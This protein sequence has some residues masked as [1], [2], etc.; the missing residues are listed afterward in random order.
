[1]R[2][3]IKNTKIKDIRPKPK[4]IQSPT[5]LPKARDYLQ[6]SK[7]LASRLQRLMQAIVVAPDTRKRPGLTH[8]EC[9]V[10][11]E[12]YVDSKQR[13]DNAHRLYPDVFKHLKTCAP[14]RMSYELLT[15]EQAQ[16]ENYDLT[17]SPEQKIE[18]PFLVPATPNAAWSKQVHSCIGGGSLGFGFT[19]SPSHLARIMA[20]PAQIAVRGPIA[21]ARSLLL[22]DSIALGSRSVQVELWL[23]RSENPDYTRL[24]V[25]VVSSSPLPEPLRVKLSWNDHQYSSAIEQGQGWIDQI[26]VSDLENANISVEFEAGQLSTSTEG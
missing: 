18:L 6:N 24:E 20:Q 7:S 21:T 14:C 16:D 9:Q 17:I 26:P 1:M 12:F 15:G 13:G 22:L 2:K 10:L 19:I 8:E 11:L 5:K 4:R 25:S 3:N 23:H